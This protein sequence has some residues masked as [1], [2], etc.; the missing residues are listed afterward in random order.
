MESYPSTL[1]NILL[2]HPSF[3]ELVSPAGSSSKHRRRFQVHVV[4]AEFGSELWTSKLSYGACPYQEAYADALDEVCDMGDISSFELVF[5]GVGLPATPVQ[6]LSGKVKALTLDCKYED[7]DSADGFVKAVPDL[8]VFFNAGF[9]CPD[10]DWAAT[11]SSVVAKASSPIPFFGTSNSELENLNDIEWLNTQGF[12]SFDLDG[13]QDEDD[14]DDAL[15]CF[16]SENPFR[17]SRVRQSGMLANDLYVKSSFLFGGAL[18]P[19]SASAKKRKE[20]VTDD[21][22][23]DDDERAAEAPQKKVKKN[24]ALI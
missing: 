2:S 1:S 19:S 12:T 5:V 11:L 23:D 17:G 15:A 6:K 14:K 8:L 10:Y 22:F 7:L 21:D 24:S 9:T 20:Q 18:K 4:G 3:E 16:F 13:D